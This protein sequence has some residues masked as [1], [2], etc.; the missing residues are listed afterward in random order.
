MRHFPVFLNVEGRRILVCG[1][2]ETAIAKLR[3]ILKTSARIEVF[4]EG[5]S[6]QIQEWEEAGAL[7]IVRRQPLASDLEN[8]AMV[9]AAHGEEQPDRKVARLA[10]QQGVLLNLVDDL[11]ASD[12]ITP[13]IVDRDPVTIAIGTEGTAPVLARKIKA[14]IEDNLSGSVGLLA[15]LGA[16]FRSRA[17]S[18][19]EGSIRRKFWSRFFFERGSQALKIGGEKGVQEVLEQL[20]SEIENEG[21]EYGRVFLMGAGPGD[22]D[23]LTVKGQRVLRDADVVVHDRLV[24]PQVLELARREAIV[25]ETGKKGFG[26]SWKQE[27]INELMIEHAQAGATVVR[28]KS[29]D[30]SVYGRLD[31][32][33]EALNQSNTAWEIIPGITAASAAAAEI[34]TSLTRRGRNSALRF[35]TG[36]DIN[37]FA[38]HD[39]VALAKPGSVA[40]IYMGKRTARF[41]SGRLLMHGGVPDRPVTVVANVS[42]PDQEI[43][44]TTLSGL[45]SD[46][47]P[48]GPAILL[49]GLKPN[50]AIADLEFQ[51]DTVDLKQGAF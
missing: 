49:L 1:G 10:E 24:G 42:R 40:A 43:H 5:P 22:P 33:I 34:G 39:W 14:D 15:R 17:A 7:T 26:K 9:Y 18:L 11:E 2:G 29:G 41:L 48:E 31:E 47:M 44:V 38:E 30:P 23:L 35:I 46:K 37:G 32:E 45:A 36:H 25:V 16:G 50:E 3:L 20:Y 19:P 12:F 27:D 8:A 4:A 51:P 6:S 28:L 21:R 13:A